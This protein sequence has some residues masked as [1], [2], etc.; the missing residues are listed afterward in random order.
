MWLSI[1]VA[2]LVLLIVLLATLVQLRSKTALNIAFALFSYTVSI[3]IVAN[4][5]GANYKDHDF[6]RYFVHIDFATG[7]LVSFTFW[8]LTSVLLHE[9]SVPLSVH[10]VMRRLGWLFSAFVI[11]AIYVSLSPWAVV[12]NSSAD[13]PLT[14]DYNSGFLLYTI[15]LGLMLLAGLINLGFAWFYGKGATRRQMSVITRGFAAGALLLGFANLVLPQITKSE[16]LNLIG[17]NLSYLGI[18]AFIIATAYA[19]IRHRLFDIRLVVARSLAYVG[20]LGF[21]SIVYGLLVLGAASLLFDLYFSIWTLVFLS[22]ATGVAALVFARLKKWFDRQTNRLFYQDAYDPQNLFNTLNKVLVSSLDIKLLAERSAGVISENIKPLYCAV[23]L[24]QGT[25]KYR[26]FGDKISELEHLDIAKIGKLASKPHRAVIVTDF[27]D[28]EKYGLLR[29]TLHNSNVSIVVRLTQNPRDSVEGLGYILLGPKKSGSPYTKQDVLTLESVANG[30]VVAIQ[31]ALRFEET[32][33]FNIVLQDK[34]EQA[35]RKLRRTNQKLREL[36]DTKDDFISMASH[37]LRTPLT[38][39]K[40][41]L[42]MVLE[43]DAGEV[44][45]TQKKMLGQAFSSSQRMVYLI[46]DLLNVSRLK[47]GKF[48]IDATPTSLADMI[49]EEMQQLTET[50]KARNL[51]LNYHKPDNFPALELDETKTR[52]VVMNFIDNAIYYTP[53]GGQIDVQLEQTPLG[54]ELRVVDNGIGVP[55]SEQHHLF[56]KFYRAGNARKAR[57]DGTG[58]GLFMAKKVVLAQGGNMIF[59][60]KEGKGSTFGFRF[61]LTKASKQ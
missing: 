42:S 16:Q 27:L 22:I 37:Q 61:P 20:S 48:V 23:A 17:G 21:V 33:R 2:V 30:L 50:A 8:Y 47:T 28:T 40:G 25:T 11:A 32:Q 9:P 15:L 29:E 38:S 34:V 1:G 36:D 7:A 60:S 3:W 12:V 44:N 6:A 43:G 54:Y 53:S 4:Y 52:Q 19:I 10:R 59:D 51:T 14:V 35:T 55:K 57:P 45:E 56:T 58:L 13:G 24:S 39:V 18:L 26:I 31:N 41:Y 46:S 49:D 5:I